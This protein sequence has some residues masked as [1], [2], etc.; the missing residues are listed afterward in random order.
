MAFRVM[1]LLRGLVL[2]LAPSLAATSAISFPLI[3]AC[4]PI[5]LMEMEVLPL[6]ISL[7]NCKIS[8]T[9]S[10]QLSLGQL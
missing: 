3:S 6:E 2:S 10:V 9:S 8:V 5:Q 7:D 1:L 4:P